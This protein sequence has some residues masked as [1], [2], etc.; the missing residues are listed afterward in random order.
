MVS[1]LPLTLFL[2]GLESMK[3]VLP[4]G[5]LPRGSKASGGEGGRLRP[6]SLWT[7]FILVHFLS[8][9]WNGYIQQR[10]GQVN[11]LQIL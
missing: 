4:T 3:F 5:C 8:T 2:T 6:L 7:G 1:Y 11:L 9:M 10:L